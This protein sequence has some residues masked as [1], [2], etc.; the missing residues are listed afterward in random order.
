MSQN[1][2]KNENAL[3]NNNFAQNENQNNI[4]IINGINNNSIQQIDNNSIRKNIQD[5][6]LNQNLNYEK[7]IVDNIELYNGGKSMPNSNRKENKL[8]HEEKAEDYMTNLNNKTEIKANNIYNNITSGLLNESLVIH[9]Y[10]K[11]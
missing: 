9:G 1:T 3:L 2:N 4:K 5:E 7:N 10:E 6:N 8:L 11:Q